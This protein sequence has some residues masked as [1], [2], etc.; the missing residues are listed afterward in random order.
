MD[1]FKSGFVSVVGLPNVGKSTFIN[2]AVGQKISIISS[3][4]QT[5]RNKII[6]IRTT[7]TSQMVF[8]DTPG[9]HTPRTKLGEFMTNAATG[10]IGD[11]DVVLFVTVAGRAVTEKE[12]EI[13]EIKDFAII[14]DCK[15]IFCM[16]A[17]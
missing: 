4:P 15:D 7:E 16:E 10:S 12:K 1:N 17:K 11:A 9:I 3:K 6:A 13:I 2:A 8:I 14:K 5:T